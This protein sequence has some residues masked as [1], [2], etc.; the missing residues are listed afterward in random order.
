MGQVDLYGGYKLN[1]TSQDMEYDAAVRRLAGSP[2][3]MVEG[4]GPWYFNNARNPVGTGV[5]LKD[6]AKVRMF[7]ASMAGLGGVGGLGVTEAEQAAGYTSDNDDLFGAL[8]ARMLGAPMR[9]S[10]Y[11]QHAVNTV[12]DLVNSNNAHFQHPIGLTNYQMSVAFFADPDPYNQMMLQNMHPIRT[13]EDVE[14]NI[15]EAARF[16]GIPVTAPT[17]APAAD[18]Y[19]YGF[20]PQFSAYTQAT[21]PQVGGEAPQAGYALA[22]GLGPQ[23]GYVVGPPKPIQTFMSMAQTPTAASAVPAGAGAGSAPQYAVDPIQPDVGTGVGTGTGTRNALNAG[24][25]VGSGPG[26][27]SGT[28]GSIGEGMSSKTM[29]YVGLAAAALFLL[30]GR[31]N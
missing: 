4:P 12:N 25:L 27:G 31:G 14:A 7:R 28:D 15:R 29:L 10:D 21:F 9:G 5:K 11:S 20:N 2:T 17:V 19:L 8:R 23:Q 22:T 16:L 1:T 3:S 24:P 30:G 26:A 6:S 18:T 13:P